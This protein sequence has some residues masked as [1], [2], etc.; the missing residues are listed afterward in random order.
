M[1]IWTS[2]AVLALMAP[3]AGAE[4]L[5]DALT[6]AYLHNPTLQAARLSARAADEETAQARANYLPSVDVLGSYGVRRSETNDVDNPDLDPASVEFSASQSLYTGG[7]RRARSALARAAVQGAREDLRS[8]EQDVLLSVIA[9][10]VD[11]RRDEEAMR[12]RQSNV[13]LLERQ[14]Q[15]AQAR[16]QVGDIT[17]TDVAQSDARLAGARSGLSQAQ[18]ALEA[19][20]ARFVE[21]IGVAPQEL[22]A[23]PPPPDIPRSLEEAVEEA[24]SLNPALRQALQGEHAAHAQTGIERSALLPQL[25]L[26]GNYDQGRDVGAPGTQVDSV[27]AAARLSVPLF[28]GGFARARV[29]QS[30][31]NERRAS[32]LTEVARR[33]VVSTVTAA[34]NDYLAAQRVVDSSRAQVSANELAFDGVQQERTVG[35]RTTLDVLNAQQELLDSRLALVGAERDVYVAQHGLLRAIGRLD[36]AMLA[37]NA[38]LYD[39]EEHGRAVNRTFLS[40]DPADIPLRGR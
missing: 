2:V 38:P 10:Y 15:E 35:L 6:Q 33:Q 39:P 36:G 11:V 3:C 9:A 40:T 14:L 37:V 7:Y 8:T 13:D 18:A 26:Q 23:P 19:S 5:N 27:E 28:E 4:T 24:L 12:I 30:R 21:I 22:E 1:R 20:R 16:F 25:T 32:E 17:R 31:I 34:W 29:R